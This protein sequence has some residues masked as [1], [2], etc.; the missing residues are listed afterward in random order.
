M[1][2]AKVDTRKRVERYFTIAEQMCS[3]GE[4]VLP[5]CYEHEIRMAE[6]RR[7][8]NTKFYKAKIIVDVWHRCTE[9]NERLIALYEAGKYPNKPSRNSQHLKAMACDIH[10]MVID[11]PG[12]KWR[13]LPSGLVKEYALLV[14]F[15]SVVMYDTFTHVGYVVG[16]T[17]V[18]VEDRRTAAQRHPGVV[19]G[20]ADEFKTHWTPKIPKIKRAPR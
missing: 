5:D 7:F 9:C 11:R 4:A 10:V 3:C 1:A 15:N 12:Q 13:E 2:I 19:V 16:R 18:R 20:S 6:F 8:L 14:G 17:G